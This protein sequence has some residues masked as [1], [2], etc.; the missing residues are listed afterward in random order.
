[1]HQGFLLVDLLNNGVN[2]APEIMPAVLKQT[3]VLRVGYVPAVLTHSNGD[4]PVTPSITRS[5]SYFAFRY[6]MKPK[7]LLKVSDHRGVSVLAQ[8]PRMP[9]YW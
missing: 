1:M 6:A 2:T 4:S 7:I 5:T 9:S 3:N 8:K